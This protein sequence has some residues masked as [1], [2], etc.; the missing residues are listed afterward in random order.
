M[1]ALLAVA[2]G[3]LSS[4]RNGLRGVVLC[5][6][7]ASFACVDPADDGGTRADEREGGRRATA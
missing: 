6:K 2:S 1:P 5:V 3:T 4:G 7:G